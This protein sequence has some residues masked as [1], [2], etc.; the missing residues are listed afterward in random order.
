MKKIIFIELLH[1]HE[2]LQNPYDIFVSKGYDV[3]V[4]I[5]EHVFKKLSDTSNIKNNCIVI[6]QP[7]RTSFSSL[8][9]FKKIKYTFSQFFEMYKNTQQIQRIIQKHNPDE[10][11]INT[12]ESP[13]M[14]PVMIYLLGIKKIKMYLVIH[15]ISRLK[16]HFLKYFLFDF[17]ITRLIKKSYKIVLLWEY[18]QFKEKNIQKK[19]IYINNRVIEKNEAK[20]FKKTTFVISGNLDYT[21]KD[22]ENVL[23]GFGEF[24]KRHP[25]YEKNIQLVL[26]WKINNVVEKWINLYNINSIVKTFDHYVDEYDMNKYMSSAHYAIVSV[27]EDSIYGK[28]KISW[29]FWD[30]VAFGIPIL[31]SEYYA[32]DY[33]GK[34]II[35][36]QN[37]QFHEILSELM[38]WKK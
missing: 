28:Y 16:V 4:I 12:I 7:W 35:R 37:T 31:L 21:H 34:N 22:I 5:G 1:H 11:Y 27:F 19:V 33:Q 32:P 3:Q 18:L 38:E 17:L 24:F 26:L 15:N 29:S 25:Q 36:F 6:P 9:F 14:V 20:K 8:N 23:K 2:C 10:L 13:F 30:A